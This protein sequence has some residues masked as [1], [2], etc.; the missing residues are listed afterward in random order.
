M[1]KITMASTMAHLLVIV[2]LLPKFSKA[3]F[4]STSGTTIL[5]PQGQEL[6][7]SGINLGNWLGKLFVG[8]YMD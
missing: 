5:D 4:V 7:F 1:W 2:F 3:N 8:E 6:F